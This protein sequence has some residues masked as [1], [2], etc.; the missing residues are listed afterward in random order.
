MSLQRNTNQP[1]ERE[2]SLNKYRSIRINL[3]LLVVLT[4]VNVFMAATASDTYFLFTAT[5]PYYLALEGAYLTG[6]FPADYYESGVEFLPDTVMYVMVGIAIVITLAYLLCYLFSGNGRYGWLI[7]AL[8]FFLIDT[9]AMFLLNG[10]ST[11]IIVDI[12]FHAFIIVILIS[13]I[14]RGIKLKRLPVESVYPTIQGTNQS[15]QL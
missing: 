2:L 11:E 5:I 7:A 8:V 3:L 13:G 10:V 12:V 15:T 1:S 9:A 4:A 14:I 6:K